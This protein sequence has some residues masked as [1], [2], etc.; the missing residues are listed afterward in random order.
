MIKEE[1]KY[2]ELTSITMLEA[3]WRQCVAELRRI[4]YDNNNEHIFYCTIKGN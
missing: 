3:M 4:N 1:Y 2:S